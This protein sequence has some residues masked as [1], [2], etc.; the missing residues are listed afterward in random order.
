M[1][2]RLKGILVKFESHWKRIVGLHLGIRIRIVC[3][4]CT[5]SIEYFET[6]IQYDKLRNNYNILIRFDIGIGLCNPFGKHF[7]PEIGLLNLYS[8]QHFT[9]EFWTFKY[10]YQNHKRQSKFLNNISVKMHLPSIAKYDIFGCGFSEQPPPINIAHRKRGTF[11]PT[12]LFTYNGK[13]IG[14]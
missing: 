7:N 2:I 12:I 13:I 10:A 3:K 6:K 14:N 8:G 11:G 1:I 4:K 5:F 9:C